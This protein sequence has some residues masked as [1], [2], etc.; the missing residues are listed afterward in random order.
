MTFN[1][2]IWNCSS[3]KILKIWKTNEVTE[4]GYQLNWTRTKKC[5]GFLHNTS[6]K[7]TSPEQLRAE[8]GTGVDWWKTW[9]FTWK[10]VIKSILCSS[11]LSMLFHL[12]A[13]AIH[14]TSSNS[15]TKYLTSLPQPFCFPTQ[16][17]FYLDKQN[18]MLYT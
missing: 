4:W 16:T 15:V 3:I 14:P 5:L 12:T 11:P 17:L 10:A 1:M 6:P 18:K 7:H 9:V 2:W 8:P 13:S